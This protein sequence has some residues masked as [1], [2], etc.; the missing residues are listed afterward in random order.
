MSFAG[1]TLTISSTNSSPSIFNNLPLKILAEDADLLIIRMK[2]NRD[3][4][5]QFSW[6]SSRESFCPARNIDF[7]LQS[8]GKHHTYYLNLKPY[9]QSAGI[10]HVLLLPFIGKGK[11]EITAFRLTRGTPG[12]KFLAAWQ[13]FWGPVGR[14]FTGKSFYIL[15][16]PLLFGKS[17][18]FQLNRLIL[19]AFLVL[20]FF[21]RPRWIIPL[22]LALWLLMEASAAVNNWIFFKDDIRF[23]WG[24]SLDEKRTVQNEPDFYPFMK[25]AETNIPPDA[26]FDIIVAPKFFCGMERARYYLFPRE[27]VRRGESAPYLLIFG[28]EPNA[29]TCKVYTLIAKFKKGAYVFKLKKEQP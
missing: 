23:F 17:V 2:T 3:G 5:G 24:K 18:F 8:A 25:Y 10:D 21:R 12:Q 28:L 9:L 27:L 13:E 6:T 15:K 14:S 19:I 22:I 11:A 4:S 7:Y 26:C 20:I 16:S 1:S 29:S